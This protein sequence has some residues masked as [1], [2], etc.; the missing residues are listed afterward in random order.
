MKKKY[1]TTVDR[2]GRIVIP[3]EIRNNFGLSKDVELG[4]EEVTK[5]I[6]L[7]PRLEKQFIVNKDGVLVVRA[8]L[9]ESIDGFLE[10]NRQSRIKYILKDV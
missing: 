7:H 4:I 3:K 2:F 8:E 1:K 10:K 9:T 5:G 6:L